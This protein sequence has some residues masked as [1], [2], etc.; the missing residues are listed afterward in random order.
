MLVFNP[1]LDTPQI[2]QTAAQVTA[3]IH[4]T[5]SWE[6]IRDVMGPGIGELLATIAAQGIAPVG[7][8]FTHHLRRPTDTFDFEISVPVS[9]PVSASGRVQPGTWPVMKMARTF[10]HGGYEGLG[11]AWGEFLDWIEANGH[12]QAPDLYECYITGPEANPDPSTWRTELSRP[13]L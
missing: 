4:V 8:V 12:A 3:F 11:D 5:V 7:P 13:L 2:I 10:Y 1:M 6:G 9:A